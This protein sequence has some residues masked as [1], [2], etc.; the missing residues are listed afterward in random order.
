MKRVWDH[1]VTYWIDID[2][3]YQVE[4]EDNPNQS[5]WYNHIN[6]AVAAIKEHVTFKMLSEKFKLVELEEFETKQVITSPW[7]EDNAPSLAY[8]ADTELL[9]DFGTGESMDV[10]QVYQNQIGTDKSID[11]PRAVMN[12]VEVFGLGKVRYKRI[13]NKNLKVGRKLNIQ[14]DQA[15][16][17]LNDAKEKNP[18]HFLGID[19]EELFEVIQN[20][21][22]WLRMKMIRVYGIE[23]AEQDIIEGF[24]YGDRADYYLWIA[25]G[26]PRPLTR[27]IMDLIEAEQENQIAIAA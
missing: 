6:R 18:E 24:E 15:I 14:L 20:P 10:I 27:F 1:E 22:Q 3:K 11:L 16:K 2:P 13:E 21:Y 23:I 19:R 8:Y 12:L 17:I 25:H 5:K 26:I 7:R 9:Y 4:T